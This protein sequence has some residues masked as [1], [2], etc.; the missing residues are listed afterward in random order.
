MAIPMEITAT[1]AVPGFSGIFKNPMIPNIK[2]A[3]IRLGI[4]EMI[5]PLKEVNIIEVMIKIAARRIPS[6]FIWAFIRP[7]AASLI[8]RFSPTISTLVPGP[9]M[10][11]A[12]SLNSRI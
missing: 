9:T 6:D 11:G 12:T 2:I 7:S 4:K 8:I 3:G 10:P 1:I 5:P